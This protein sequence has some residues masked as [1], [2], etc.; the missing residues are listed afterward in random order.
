MEL[1]NLRL[2][3]PPYNITQLVSDHSQGKLFFLMELG[4]LT[5]FVN[6]TLLRKII[7]L[8]SASRAFREVDYGVQF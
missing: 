8:F 7:I 2:K 1:E 4:F 5:G 3:I 6:A